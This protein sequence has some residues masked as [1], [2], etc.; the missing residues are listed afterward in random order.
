MT[1]WLLLAGGAYAQDK[2]DR[3]LVLKLSTA[4]GP[5]FALGKAGER[6]AQL[7]NERA[8]GAFELMQ[9]PGLFLPD[10]IPAASSGR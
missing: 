4:Q 8:A 5:A 10:A 7:V 1:A 3:P 6:W 9:Y 2:V